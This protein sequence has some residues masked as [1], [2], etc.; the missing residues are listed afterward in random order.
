MNTSDDIFWFTRNKQIKLFIWVFA[1]CIV[2]SIISSA[3]L[4]IGSD[5][6]ITPEILELLIFISLFLV[7][8]SLLGGLHF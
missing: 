6:A 4:F 1:V 3:A 2:G 5:K 7:G 8:I